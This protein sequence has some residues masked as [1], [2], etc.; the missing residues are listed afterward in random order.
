MK[1]SLVLATLNRDK[2]VEIFLSSLINQVYKNFEVIIV[3]Q[4]KDGLI[5][6]IINYYSKFLTINHVKSVVL[7]LSL[8]RNLGLESVRGDVIAFPDDDC[9]YPPNL[10]ND[11]Y[12]KFLINKE[13][14]ILTGSTIDK[15]TKYSYL[16]SPSNSVFVTPYNV[17]KTAISFT[18][19]IKASISSFSYFDNKL[20]VGAPFGSSEE[21]DYLV[22]FLNSGLIICYYPD[23]IVF[24]PITNLNES[25]SRTFNYALGFGAF[26]RKHLRGHNYYYAFRFMFFIFINIIRVS[27]LNEPT[28]N[29]NSLKGKLL[30]FIRYK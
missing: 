10:L 28:K 4:N 16:K 18:I 9:E 12:N 26:H 29:W 14:D 27:I 21:T 24:H 15:L 13:V 1:F 30:G 17:F 19:F 7:G 2:E 6:D 23:I 5:D 25:T 8:N 3:D 20:G 22:G 11:V